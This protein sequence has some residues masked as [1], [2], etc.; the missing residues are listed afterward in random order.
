MDDQTLA[1]T[2]ADGRTCPQCGASETGFFCRNCGALLYGEDLVL[3]PRCHQIV[4]DGEYCNQCGQGMEGMALR[5]SQLAMAG[6]EFW[7]TSAPDGLPADPEETLLLPDESVSLAA[8]ELP[9][10]LQELPSKELPAESESRIYPALRPIDEEHDRLPRSGA[11]LTV[12]IASILIL[13]LGVTFLAILI[14]VR[15]GG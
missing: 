15:T 3:C 9:D 1:A 14:L 6:D 5:L 10:W 8:P 12:V 2:D 11:F 4:P 13:V 7:V